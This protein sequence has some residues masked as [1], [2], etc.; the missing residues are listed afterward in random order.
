M[1]GV[2]VTTGQE[3]AGLRIGAGAVWPL[4]A[5]ESLILRVFVDQL[6]PRS[7]SC[8]CLKAVTRPPKPV[9][10]LLVHPTTC[11]PL[12]PSVCPPPL[13]LSVHPSSEHG[14]LV[15]HRGARDRV[16][17]RPHPSPQGA[18]RPVGTRGFRRVFLKQ[19]KEGLAA[20]QPRASG[21]LPKWPSPGT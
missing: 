9:P 11:P 8:C 10:S 18:H 14:S 21:G 16:E 17:T 15:F 13:R 19:V 7:S 6:N 4:A 2:V 12:R 3:H 20:S 1:E 5:G